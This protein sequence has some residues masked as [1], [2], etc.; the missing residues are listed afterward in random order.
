MQHIWQVIGMAKTCET[1]PEL[2]QRMAETFGTGP[3]Q[4][5]IKIPKQSP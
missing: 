1:M 2:R 4:L 3:I 5:T